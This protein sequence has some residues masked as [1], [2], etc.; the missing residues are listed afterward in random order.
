[1]LIIQLSPSLQIR[2]LTS[3]FIFA[4]LSIRTV[5]SLQ[6]IFTQ[7]NNNEKLNQ[8]VGIIFLFFLDATKGWRLK[9]KHF[10]AFPNAGIQTVYVFTF[11]EFN[12]QQVN[13]GGIKIFL[14]QFQAL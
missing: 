8:N 7:E 12:F 9:E 6:V 13:V 5:L 4:L 14:A 11:G 2:M 10:F 3:T 1:M